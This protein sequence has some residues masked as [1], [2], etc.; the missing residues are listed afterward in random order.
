[1]TIDMACPLCERSGSAREF[2]VARGRRHLRCDVCALIFVDPGQRPSVEEERA[3][4]LQHKNSWENIGYVRFLD[5]FAD[6]VAAAMPR[7]ARGLDF[8]CGPAPILGEILTARGYPTVSY[9]PIFFD[10]ER[11]LHGS[12]DFVSCCEVVEH[13]HS[14]RR[15][16][17]QIERCLPH[18]SLIA[19][20]T[21][22][23]DESITFADWWYQRDPTHVSFYTAATMKWIARQRG[24]E[25]TARDNSVTLFSLPH[26]TDRTGVRKASAQ[27]F[28]IP[29]T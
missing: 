12:Y 24:W 26:S 16:L 22:L 18:G 4:Y 6:A 11:L 14:P 9:D 20:R 25:H 10:D 15:L 2:A 17:D 1:M 21:V 3:R 28:G 5:R 29:E 8:G 7:G 19:I 23:F 13:A 27:A